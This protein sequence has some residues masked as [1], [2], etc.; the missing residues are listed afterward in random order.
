[1]TTRTITTITA[2]NHPGI[3]VSSVVLTAHEVKHPDQ[4]EV[5]AS[6]VTEHCSVSS[7]EE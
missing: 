1:M 6:A 3:P 4:L 5:V 2:I 7:P